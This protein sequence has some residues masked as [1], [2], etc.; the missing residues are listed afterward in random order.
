MR[1]GVVR[2]LLALLLVAWLS[3][4]ASIYGHYYIPMMPF[5]A[6]LSALA[7][8]KLAGWASA[9][10]PVS[11][12]WTHRALTA[13]V[14]VLVLLADAPWMTR[15]HARFAADKLG[16]GNPFAESVS[17]GQRVAQLT[18]PQDY[19][20]VAGSEPQILCY[21][22]RFSPS[23]F[24]IAYPMMFPTPLAGRYQREAIRDL[25]QNPPQLIVWATSPMSWGRQKG[26]PPDFLDFLHRLL[27]SDYQAI[28]GYAS[29]AGPSAW[30]EPFEDLHNYTLIVYKKKALQ[31]SP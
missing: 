10:F 16:A 31:K 2:G 15:S 27:A 1:K 22:N 24:V 6:L 26:T 13:I 9:N 30:I 19:V 20:F 11:E 5:W 3:A 17:A 14:V 21:A 7:L 25:Q 18:S 29:D 28:G 8:Q 23:R 12:T 4:N